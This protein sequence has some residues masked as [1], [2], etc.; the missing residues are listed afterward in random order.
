MNKTDQIPATTKLHTRWKQGGICIHNVIS[1]SFKFHRG[2]KTG[3]CGI[4]YTCVRRVWRGSISLREGILIKDT[5]VP[6]P[7]GQESNTGDSEFLIQ[8]L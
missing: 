7:E 5:F 8:W 3:R 4:E 2:K 6:K 1:R